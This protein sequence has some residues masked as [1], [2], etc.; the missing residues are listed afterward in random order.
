MTELERAYEALAGMHGALQDAYEAEG[1]PD[2]DAVA[3]A[4]VRRWR[5]L[6]RAEKRAGAP[7]A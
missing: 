1:H 6:K 4:F 5:K 2:Y 7:R 3:D